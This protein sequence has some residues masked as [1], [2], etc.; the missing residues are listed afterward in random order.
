MHL[1]NVFCSNLCWCSFQ[2][3]VLVSLSCYCVNLMTVLVANLLFVGLLVV[4]TE[5]ILLVKLNGHC[6]TR[7]V[8]L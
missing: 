7:Y 5:F 4:K 1:P 6:N 3:L 8:H 2:T